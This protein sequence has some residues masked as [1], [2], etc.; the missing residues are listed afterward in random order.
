DRL[1]TASRLN[2][3][4]ADLRFGKVQRSARFDGPA[5]RLIVDSVFSA[6]GRVFAATKLSEGPNGTLDIENGVWEVENGHLLLSVP[7][8]L[9]GTRI[10]LN[11]SGTRLFTWA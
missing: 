4:I 3:S 2:F 5:A 1:F 10:A 8:S 11:P 9:S 6:D 7:A